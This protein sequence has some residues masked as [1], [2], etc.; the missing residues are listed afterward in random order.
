MAREKSKGRTRKRKR[1]RWRKGRGGAEGGSEYYE[2]EGEEMKSKE[3][4][5]YPA[6]QGVMRETGRDRWGS[7]FNDLRIN[8]YHNHI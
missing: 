1:K 2:A 7:R 6:C 4:F 8:H 3:I 5:Y